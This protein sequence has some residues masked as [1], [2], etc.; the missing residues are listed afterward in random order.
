MPG[1]ANKLVVAF[2][3]G[4][5]VAGYPLASGISVW[6]GAPSQMFAIVFRGILVL[7]SCQVIFL[8]ISAAAAGTRPSSDS[9]LPT[10]YWACLL[11]MWGIYSVRFFLDVADGNIYSDRLVMIGTFVGSTLIPFFALQSREAIPRSHLVFKVVFYCV[12]VASVL[13]MHLLWSTD[14]ISHLAQLSGRARSISLNPISFSMLGAQLSI[15]CLYVLVTRKST[16]LVPN[17]VVLSSLCLGIVVVLIGGSRGPILALLVSLVPLYFL[18]AG[19]FQGSARLKVLLLCA[20]MLAALF[21]TAV[22]LQNVYN[23]STV[24]R[25]DALVSGGLA[26]DRTSNVRLS[27]MGGAIEQFLSSPI[28]GDSIVVDVT[29]SYPH[30]IPVELLM[31]TGI[32]GFLSYLALLIWSLQASLRIL[33]HQQVYG[34]IVLLY[35]QSLTISMVSGSVWS[36]SLM[37]SLMGAIIGLSKHK[38][39]KRRADSQLLNRSVLPG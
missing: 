17:Y 30:N 2:L 22:V 16:V 24:Q 9:L 38:P 10:V 7:L 28:L 4:L 34:W 21:Y 1:A 8:A 13:N 33:A 20:G 3:F 5:M 14:L 26:E 32:F 23:V 27:G 39:L 31:S 29:G 11:S 35:A 19:A 25:V 15:L 37:W 12:L 6:S 36:S 18:S